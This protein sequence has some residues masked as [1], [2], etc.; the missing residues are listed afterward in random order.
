MN[1]QLATKFEKFARKALSKQAQSILVFDNDDGSYELFNS[2]FVKP[3]GKGM[4]TVDVPHKCTSK[5][6]SSLKNAVT[7]C[8]LNKR[9]Q[10]KAM[11]RVEEL[12]MLLTGCEISIQINMRLVKKAQDTSVKLIHLAKLS[13]ARMKLKAMQEELESYVISSKNWQESQFDKVK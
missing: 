4:Y 3:N 10:Y 1:E 5:I 7:W 9:N 12:D 13:E 11:V 6:F 2:Y 8:V